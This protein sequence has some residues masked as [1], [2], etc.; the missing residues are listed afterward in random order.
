MVWATGLKFRKRKKSDTFMGYPF[1][2]L[3]KLSLWI[4]ILF[5]D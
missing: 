1:I 5:N 2:M 4:N 3:F